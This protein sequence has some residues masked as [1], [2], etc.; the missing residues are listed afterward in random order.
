MVVGMMSR[1]PRI[2]VS[3]CP[4][5]EAK[6]YGYRTANGIGKFSYYRP[7]YYETLVAAK[8][9]DIWALYDHPQPGC[10]PEI[11]VYL[12]KYWMEPEYAFGDLA[13]FTA[14]YVGPLIN[15]MTITEAFALEFPGFMDA[16]LKQQQP[17][18]FKK[19]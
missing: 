18:L 15:Q 4:P 9:C 5:P 2:L 19:G 12:N 3:S 8:D 6:I 11:S 14:L 13:M 7:E 17:H 10:D 1:S 16:R